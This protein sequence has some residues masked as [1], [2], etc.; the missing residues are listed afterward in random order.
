MSLSED[1]TRHVGPDD[2]QFS[3][4]AQVSD[5]WPFDV[6]EPR[7]TS[8]HD[9]ISDH[10][11]CKKTYTGWFCMHKLLSHLPSS[12]PALSQ[13]ASLIA[14]ISSS[15]FPKKRDFLEVW[16][17]VSTLGFFFN[18][19]P[20]AKL[21]DQWQA[22]N[23]ANKR[24]RSYKTQRQPSMD[25][26][27][28]TL[29]TPN[30]GSLLAELHSQYWGNKAQFYR[31]GLHLGWEFGDIHYHSKC[32]LYLVPPIQP[33]GWE[34]RNYNKSPTARECTCKFDP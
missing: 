13:T 19:L 7:A 24:Q 28:L 3:G 14:K 8:Y 29:V 20:F 23:S 21:S 32:A 34:P 11:S 10:A 1:N 4:R 22:Y 9:H 16:T 30:S 18:K 2:S 6:R 26:N 5:G 12:L 27:K 17:P 25:I 15:P 33:K 31:K